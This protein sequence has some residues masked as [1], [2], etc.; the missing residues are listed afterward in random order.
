[1][2]KRVYT[3]V[4]HELG[5]GRALANTRREAHREVFAQERIETLAQRLGPQAPPKAGRPAV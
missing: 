1:M 3:Y 4:V 2:L 5:N